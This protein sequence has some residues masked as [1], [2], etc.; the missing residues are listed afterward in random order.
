MAEWLPVRK[1]IVDGILSIKLRIALSSQPAVYNLYMIPAV[2]F[3]RKQIP[4]T[5]S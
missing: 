2:P 5:S 1:G 4:L 3:S